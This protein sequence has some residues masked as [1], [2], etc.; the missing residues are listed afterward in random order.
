[1]TVHMMTVAPEMEGGLDL[2]KELKSRGW[3]VAIG[4]TSAGVEVLEKAH[5]Y[6]AR[7]ITHLMNAMPQLHHRDPGVVGWALAKDDVMCGLIADGVHIDPLV[8]KLIFK[9]KTASKILLKSDSMAPTGLGDGEFQVWD[10]TINVKGRLTRG[11]TGGL[12]GSVITM[13]DGVK[14]MKSIGAS[15]EELALMASYNP[16][17]LLRLNDR[18]GKLEVGRVA[19][20]VALDEESNVKLTIIDG[21]VV[22]RNL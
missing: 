21:Q 19:D 10:E 9:C 17:S 12:A 1:S 7:Y 2:V 8:L 3:V 4:H 11:R 20:L 13:Q 16:A 22:Y 14:M 15:W 18:F 5:S 6:G